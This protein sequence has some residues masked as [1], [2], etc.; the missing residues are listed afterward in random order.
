MMFC[1]CSQKCIITTINRL[2]DTIK[3]TGITAEK[4]IRDKYIKYA[5]DI[6]NV[7][8]KFQPISYERT[9]GWSL[10]AQLLTKR[11]AKQTANKFNIN[12]HIVLHSMITEISSILLKS[13]AN[14]I[15]RKK[16]DIGPCDYDYFD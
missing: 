1:D 2:A 11:I 13:A 15:I 4:A 16:T 9:G 7:S 8:W 5:K 14:M 10:P 3:F 12:F 6:K